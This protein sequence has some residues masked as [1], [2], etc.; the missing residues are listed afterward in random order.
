[1]SI[2]TIRWKDPTRLRVCIYCWLYFLRGLA[3]VVETW[4]TQHMKR[5]VGI[6]VFSRFLAD[7]PDSFGTHL[8]VPL[9]G[10]TVGTGRKAAS[11]ACTYISLQG[12]HRNG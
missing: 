5:M 7:F 9:A 1:M 3:V 2:R 12:V 6:K 8:G 11:N 10:A 4:N